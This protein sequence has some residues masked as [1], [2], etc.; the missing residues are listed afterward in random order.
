VASQ[1]SKI[2]H[3]FARTQSGR[4]GLALEDIGPHSGDKV[5]C[6]SSASGSLGRPSE[7]NLAYKFFI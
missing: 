6:W 2:G 7:Y 4:R 3:S 1:H 5:P